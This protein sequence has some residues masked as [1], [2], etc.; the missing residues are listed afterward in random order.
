MKKE[1]LEGRVEKKEPRIDPSTSPYTPHNRDAAKE[2]GMRYDT[3]RKVYRDSDG[4]V[5]AD[6]FGQPLG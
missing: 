1:N 6:K 5:V 4:C 2:L 3:K